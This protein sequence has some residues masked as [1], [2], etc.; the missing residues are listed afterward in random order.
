MMNMD[1]RDLDLLDAELIGCGGFDLI[2]SGPAADAIQSGNRDENAL[3]DLE[4]NLRHPERLILANP[5]IQAEEKGL[6]KEWLQ[7]RDE[8]VR[9]ELA[10]ARA[11]ATAKSSPS[12]PAAAPP[13]SPPPPLGSNAAVAEAQLAATKQNQIIGGGAVALALVLGG[14]AWAAMK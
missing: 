6:A 14:V 7:L 4:F 3:T 5:K 9:P 8:V 1:L 10:K 11:A 13:L 2:G 12:A